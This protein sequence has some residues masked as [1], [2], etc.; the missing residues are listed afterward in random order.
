MSNDSVNLINTRLQPGVPTAATSEP[1]Q[2]LA[3]AEKPLKRF[4]SL[5]LAAPG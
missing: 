3:G 1:F 5:S 4:C 2:R